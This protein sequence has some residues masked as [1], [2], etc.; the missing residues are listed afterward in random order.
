MA[1]DVILL[2]NSSWRIRRVESGKV[3]VE[4][5]G[6]APSTVPFWLGE[7]PARTRELSAEVAA[8]REAVA[9]RLDDA[10]AAVR[11]LTAE[12]A[13]D[14]RGALLVRDYIAAAHAALGAVPT[15]STVVVERFFDEAGGM[16]LVIHAPFGGRINRAWGMALRKRLLPAASTSSCRRRPPT[17]ACCSR[18]GPS[19]A[20][21]WRRCSRCSTRAGSEELLIQAVL[22]A[23]MFMTRWRWNASRALA[24]LRWQ[25]GAARA[26]VIQRMRAE[27]LLVAVFPAQLACQDNAE[28]GPVEIPN[29]P[30]V[31]ETL[32]DCLGEAMD[33]DGL[34]ACLEAIHARR[35]RRVARDTPEPSVFSHEILNANPYAFLDDAP[36]EERRAR[37]VTLRRGLPAAVA[38]DY[39][40]LDPAAIAAVVEEAQPDLRSADE[41]HDLLLE[42]G[43]LPE[44]EATPWAGYLEEL[45]AARRAARAA[46]RGGASSG[47]PPSR[48]L[49]AAVW[50]TA[51]FEPDVAEP[52]ARRAAAWSDRE[53]ALVEVVRARLGWSARPRRWPWRR[54]SRF[55]RRGGRGA[56]RGGSGG[57]CLARALHAGRCCTRGGGV[58]RSPAPCPHPSPDAGRAAPLDRAGARRGAD[59]LP[60][61]LAARTP[62][63]QQH[64]R[65]GL[66]RVIERLEGFEAAAGAWEREL[67][68]AR[69]ARYDPGA[70]DELCS[71]RAR[72]SGA[73]SACI[74]AP[75]TRAAGF[76]P[77]CRWRCCLRRDLPWLL[78]PREGAPAAEPS[79]PAQDVLAHLR[80]AGASFV[81]DIAA[82]ACA[83]CGSRWRRRSASW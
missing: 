45:I 17:T 78:E 27:D 21:R 65:D 73:A 63:T 25:G 42:L 22:Q 41:L 47:W 7:G 76:R 6:G 43:A 5:A 70:L 38:D 60:P 48:S 39:G 18:S 34:R 44:P 49:A 56:G 9:A 19:T 75:A 67:L 28:P 79:G 81:E 24:L 61:V 29:H 26:P 72:R 37:A 3:R 1:G 33:V 36:L 11:W 62:G 55:P 30:L 20:S 64:G 77:R 31:E 2:G 59:P 83:A 74:P 80:R 16:Q 82:A 68:P 57:R 14:P 8:V 46:E 10:E 12:T 54:I 66:L 53:G 58:V 13:L 50:P 51:R 15:Q 23:P 40:R 69:V 32:R 52:P 4:D 71:W 35:I